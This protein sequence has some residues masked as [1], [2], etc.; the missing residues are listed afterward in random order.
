MLK[1]CR[2]SSHLK[3]WPEVV[4]ATH[5]LDTSAGESRRASRGTNSLQSQAMGLRGGGAQLKHRKGV[6]LNLNRKLDRKGVG[7]NLT[8]TGKGWGSSSETWSSAK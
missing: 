4:V 5:V 6:G 8:Q 1:S 3:N 7:L 2:V